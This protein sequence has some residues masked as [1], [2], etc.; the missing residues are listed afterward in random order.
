MLSFLPMTGTNPEPI[1]AES[2]PDFM[3]SLARGLRVIRAFGDGQ[4]EQ[5]IA[6][7]ARRTELSRAA[8]RRCLHTLTALRYARSHGRMYELTPSILR[9][10]FA[11]LGSTTPTQGAQPVLERL[12]ERLHES[13]SM[14]LLV[15]EHGEEVVYVARAAV[16]HVLS[17]ALSIGSRLPSSCTSMGRVLVAYLDDKKR[18]RYLSRV[19]L[20]AHTPRTIVDRAELRAEL[21][22]VRSQGYA[23]VDQELELGLCSIAVP[24]RN[25]QGEVVAA[26]N[27]G[28]HVGRAAPT[29]VLQRDFLPALLEAA[30]EIGVGRTYGPEGRAAK[31]IRYE[32]LAASRFA[33]SSRTT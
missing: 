2:D 10:G 23:I 29:R 22:R 28:V 11:Y 8:V 17:V 27:V 30:K 20:V 4:H 12:A 32:E 19:K 21:D 6:E 5:S 15:G 1:P 24:V 31:A 26:I 25:H 18:N 33:R 13:S 16:G 9:L 14:A 7:I 3:E